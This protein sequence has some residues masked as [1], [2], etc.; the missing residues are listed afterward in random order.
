[1]KSLFF[2]LGMLVACGPTPVEVKDQNGDEFQIG[3]E[4][5]T[6]SHNVAEEELE[7]VG[8]IPAADCQHIDVGDKACNFRLSDQNGETWD[9]YEHE[10]DVIVLDF[11]T[12]WC[13]PCQVAGH[14][15]Q[16]IQDDYAGQGVQFVTILL[17]GATGQPPTEAEI[18]TWVI[19]HNITTAPILQGS[20]EKMMDPTHTG[21]QGYLLSAFP[22]YIYI[23]RDLKFY[24][25]HVGFSDEYVRQT[26]EE[27]L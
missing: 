14:Y 21:V 7:P 22:T 25:G 23:G 27:G 16:P 26:I 4:D 24:K 19:E 10:G 15:A 2:V 1:M 17:D 20:R 6:G 18:N 5:H 12:V 11:S 9:L 3:A 8:V 13:G